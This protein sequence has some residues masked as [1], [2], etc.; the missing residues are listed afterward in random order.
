MRL[1][2]IAL[3]VVLNAFSVKADEIKKG[4]E[5]KFFVATDGNDKNPGTKNKPF[6]S[7]ERAKQAVR[8]LKSEG[9]VIVYIRRGR[10]E[11]SRT[12]EFNANDAGRDSFKVIYKAYDQEKPVLSGGK[13]IRA[14]EL[15][16]AAKNIYKAHVGYD[17]FRQLYIDGEPAVRARFPN[18]E[19]ESNFGPYLRMKG[20][21]VAKQRYRISVDDWKEV[22]EVENKE[23]MELVVQPHW[24]HHN[25]RYKKHEVEGEFVWLSPQDTESASCFNKGEG[26]FNNAAFHFEN[27]YELI[28]QSGEWYLDRKESVLYLKV[29]QGLE[30]ESLDIEYP[31]LDV[32]IS[33]VGSKESPVKNL[34]FEGISFECTNWISPSEIGL[35]ATQFVQPYSQ[36]FNRTYGNKAYP[37]A[38]I[39]AINADS[40][41]LRNCAIRKTGANGVQFFANV[42]NADIE[43]N[44]FDQIGANAIEIDVH[45][46]M[47]AGEDEMSNN[48][49][50]WNNTITRCGRSYTNGGGILAHN[51]NGMIIEH[52][53][54][55]DMPYSGMQIGDQPGGYNDTGC[56]SN[57]IRKNHIHHVVQLHDD[58][59][60]IYTLGGNQRGTV[61]EEN[62]I[63]DIERSPWA[64]DWF[65][66]GV[67]LDNYS[68]FILVRNNVIK[69]SPIGGSHNHSR[70]NTFENN[71]EKIMGCDSII[72]KAGP[73][74]GCNPRKQ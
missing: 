8:E 65:V 74:P 6:A 21:D 37:Q 23:R 36:S 50:I 55:Y 59:G 27:A 10:Y 20:A 39:K 62:Y 67:Y 41:V 56:H 25:A 13:K 73:L 11:L 47:N 72:E 29:D 15:H 51:V 68:Q 3:F 44:L 33:V 18:K 12:I 5:T 31:I 64:G 32:L 61:I 48:L 9:D 63:H 28:D 53:E 7:F 60:A 26:F 57:I 66:D 49:A 17:E 22:E 16:D 19:S 46:K 4:K 43:G 42:D 30:V 35:S 24:I 52:N 71:G 40:F 2:F 34:E 38:A 58:G 70:N 1:L 69:N 54:L 14:W 45:A